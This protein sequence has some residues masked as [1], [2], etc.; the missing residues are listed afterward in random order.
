MFK[1][2]YQTANES[3]LIPMGEYEMYV[4]DAFINYTPGTGSQFINLQL[5][6]RSDVPEQNCKGRKFTERMFTTERAMPITERKINQLS[7]AAALDDGKEYA[8][9]GEWCLDVM[10]KFVRVKVTHSKAT[11][12]YEARAQA[13]KFSP[14][15]HPAPMGEIIGLDVTMSR[16]RNLQ[17]QPMPKQVGFTPVGAQAGF[18]PADEEPL[19]F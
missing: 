18:V 3:D 15:Q 14:T 1:V 7:Y 9:L 19:P 5:C 6:V 2:N 11:E 10:G 16:K 12:Q 8:D 13:G 17:A 4:A